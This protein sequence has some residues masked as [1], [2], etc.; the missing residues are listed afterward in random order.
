MKKITAILA[1]LGLCLSLAA[2][3]NL[4]ADG[5]STPTEPPYKTVFVHASITRE[6][7][8]TVSRTEYLFDEA[9]RVKEVVVYTNGTETKRH[10]VRCDEYGNYTHWTSDG[11]TMEYSYDSEGHS[12]GMSMYIDGE[13]VSTTSYTWENGL[14]TSVSSSMAGQ[15]M[16]Q[17]VLMTYDSGGKLLRQDSYN[18]DVLVNYSIYAYDT[19]GRVSTMTT[20]QPDGSLYSV[21]THTWDGNCQTIVTADQ[22]GTVMQTAVMTYDDHQNLLT[23]TIY[24]PQ[25]NTISKETH[26]WK[27]LQVDPDCPRASV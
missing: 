24:N 10:S 3:T 18:A 19:Q 23:H 26:T 13:L 27:A 2:C 5:P 8:S 25:G 20:Y 9:D 6:S 21:G 1:S 11:Y 15:N 22:N 17:K 4:P 14:R 12:L 7:G 16:T